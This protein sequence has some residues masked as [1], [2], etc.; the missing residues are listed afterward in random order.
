MTETDIRNELKQFRGTEEYHK[1]LF[2]VAKLT[3]S[4][5]S[6]KRVTWNAWIARSRYW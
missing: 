3:V 4:W 2:P 6:Q 5:S 1:P